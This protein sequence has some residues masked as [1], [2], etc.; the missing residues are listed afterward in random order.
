MAE[1]DL[2]QRSMVNGQQPMVHARAEQR[3]EGGGGPPAAGE[4]TVNGQQST[5]NGQP[6]TVNGRQS[7]V[8]G[9][10]SHHLVPFLSFVR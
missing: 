1:V 10:G 4:S 6:S 2:L 7:T 3:A 9:R 5:V 8:I